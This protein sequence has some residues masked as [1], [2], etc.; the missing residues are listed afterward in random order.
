MVA[1]AG[2]GVGTE[3]AIT[4]AVMIGVIGM[5]GVITVGVVAIGIGDKNLGPRGSDLAGLLLHRALPVEAVSCK[6]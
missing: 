5:A 6:A 1:V 4:I 3:I 2:G